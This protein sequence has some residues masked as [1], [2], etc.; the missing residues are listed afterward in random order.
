[1]CKGEKFM[2]KKIVV[3]ILIFI[4]LIVGLLIGFTFFGSKNDT[5]IN[6]NENNGNS[7]SI[8]DS[9]NNDTSNKMGTKVAVIYFSATGNTKKVASYINEEVNGT[10]IEIEAS[11]SY[12]ADDLNY[13]NSNSRCNI[14]HNDNK[15]RP[16]IKNKIDIS[17]YDTIYL[18]YPIWWNDAPRIIYTFLDTYDLTNKRVILFATAASSS[19]ENSMSNLKNYQKNV[20]F[21]TGKRLSVS[22]IEVSNWIKD[23]NS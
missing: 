12:T 10:L 15:T 13:N 5:N 9:T 7:G 17:S 14:E 21:V 19:I 23:L 3:S 1:M 6:N 2:N 4:L 22:K 8:N 18:G 16:G 20:N 11:D